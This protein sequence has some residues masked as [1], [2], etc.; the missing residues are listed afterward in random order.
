MVSF[1]GDKMAEKILM[2]TVVNLF[3]IVIYLTFFFAIAFFCYFDI[4]LCKFKFSLLFS[5]KLFM[6]CRW[7]LFPVVVSV[8][9]REP[10]YC[11]KGIH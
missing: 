10:L 11:H 6:C 1:Y 7:S 5:N 4:F 2:V 9:T 8:H 3:F